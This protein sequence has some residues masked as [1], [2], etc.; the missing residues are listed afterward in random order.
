MITDKGTVLVVVAHPDDEV[1]GFG[2]TASV[3]AKHGR[4]VVACILSGAAEARRR[5]PGDDALEED[6][7]AAAEVL[8]MSKPI[9]GAFPNIKMNSVPHLDLV[10]FIEEAI[11]TTGAV[12]LVTHHVGDLNDD[13]RQVARA[14]HAAARLSQRRNNTSGLVSLHAMEVPSSTDWAFGG[15]G[16]H[17]SVTSFFEIGTAGLARKQQALACYREV[18]RPYPHPRNDAVIEA[19]AVMRGAQAGLPLAEGFET[20]HIDLSALL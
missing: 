8:G 6:A 9:F 19:W 13:H 3:L 12:H 10:Q 4:E 1:L 15:S 7:V 18:T 20:L 2:G 11:D 16:E 5:H 17:F 14:T